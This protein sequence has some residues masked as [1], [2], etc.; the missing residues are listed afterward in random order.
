MHSET[1]G[2]H[3]KRLDALTK[4]HENNNAIVF[5]GK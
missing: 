5:L 2:M 1:S 3:L 4:F